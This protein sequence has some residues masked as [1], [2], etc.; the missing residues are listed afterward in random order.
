MNM[1]I[2]LNSDKGPMISHDGIIY[3]FNYN[4]DMTFSIWWRKTIG[5]AML[6][7]NNIKKYRKISADMGI[8]SYVIQ[9]ATKAYS[10]GQILGAMNQDINM[11]NQASN[12]TDIGTGTVN[13]GMEASD[14][15]RSVP[16]AQSEAYKFCHNC[17]TKYQVGTKFCQNCGAKL[18]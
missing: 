13:Q 6:T 10:D 7:A 18:G 11:Q 5:A 2:E 8:I 3:D 16:N 17:G 4:D 14:I 9:N 12:M 1:T 15:N